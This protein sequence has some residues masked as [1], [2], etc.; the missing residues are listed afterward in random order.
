MSNKRTSNPKVDLVKKDLRYLQLLSDQ[1]RNAAEASTEI[2]NLKAILSLPKGTEHF[3]ADVHGEYEAFDHVLKNASGSIMRKIKEVLG[4]LL[5]ESEMRELATL[6]YYPHRKLELIKAQEDFDDNRYRVII[7]RLVLLLRKVGEKYTRSKVR[8]A[9]PPQYSYI[10]EELLHEDR[11]NAN[12][13]AYFASILDTIIE[14]NQADDFVYAISDTIK[15]LAIDRLHIV[16]DIYDRGPGAQHI[17]DTVTRYHNVD[18]Q[19][20]NHDVLWMGAAAGNASCMATVV[21]IALR[22]ANLDTIEDGYGINLLPLARFAME[23]YAKDPCTCFTPKLGDADRVYDDKSIYLISQM[24]KAISIIQFK[25]EHQLI[26]AHPEY[27]ME[28]RDLLHKI[29]YAAGTIDLSETAPNGGY[30]V[31][32]MK[33]KHFPTIDP[34]D[35]YALTEAEQDVVDKLM[36]SFVQSEKLQNHMTAMYRLG[37]LYLVCNNN[38]LFHASMP[39][40]EDKEFKM[41][42]INGA[43]YK[44]RSLFNKVDELIRIAGNSKHKDVEERQ[45]AVDYMWYL[46]CGPDSPLFDKSAMTTLERYFVADKDTHKEHKGYYYRYRPEEEIADMIL[47]EFG[48]EGVD[49]H[50][51]NGHVPV[52][53][54]KGEK[55]IMAGG[56]IMV[57]DGGFSRAYQSSTGIAGYTLIFNSQGL[58]L[59]QHEPFTSCRKAIEEMDDIKS[60]TVVREYT[61]HRILVE[62]TDIGAMLQKQVEDLSNLLVAFR[63]GLIKERSSLQK[64]PSK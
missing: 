18:I 12:K 5:S 11:N 41:V 60:V 14:I 13:S 36:R 40:N 19:W 59:V 57:I 34:K 33:D 55:P 28:S 1:F 29:D 51:I 56:K 23:T 31:H 32:P 48:L 17:M 24:H 2:I 39:L 50:I 38:L 7:N 43:Q 49:C 6:I 4:E 25:L 16:G 35:P 37:S 63:L 45:R 46:W 42:T 15:R 52:K 26:K 64:L 21:R 20:G 9:L 54:V 22:Y 47:K 10:I 8:K 44:G 53:A 62:D 27:K 3:L 61:S 58:Q 30:G